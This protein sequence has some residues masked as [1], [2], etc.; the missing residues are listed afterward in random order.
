MI[1]AEQKQ[2]IQKAIEFYYEEVEKSGE[3]QEHYCDSEI[4]AKNI[5]SRAI[6]NLTA[7]LQGFELLDINL[8][9]SALVEQEKEIINYIEQL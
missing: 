9:D 1:N 7:N 8:N 5:E 4:T 3:Y 6:E 2:L